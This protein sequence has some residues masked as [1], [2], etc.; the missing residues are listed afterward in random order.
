VHRG[1]ARGRC[2]EEEMIPVG[3]VEII[4]DSALALLTFHGLRFSWGRAFTEGYFNAHVPLH[5]G[6]GK[7]AKTRF[8]DG[9]LNSK[10]F[11]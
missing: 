10:V 1:A 3:V 4:Q 5:M 11:P 6:Q 8:A 9:K 2:V 7:F